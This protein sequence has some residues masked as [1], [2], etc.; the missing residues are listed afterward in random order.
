ME[1]QVKTRAHPKDMEIMI[2]FSAFCEPPKKNLQQ[3][4]ASR[5]QSH[6]CLAARVMLSQPVIPEE[7]MVRCLG[8]NGKMS[9]KVQPQEDPQ[10]HW[11][12]FVALLSFW[13]LL[14]CKPPQS[15]D[16]LAACIVLQQPASP[17][18]RKKLGFMPCKLQEKHISTALSPRLNRFCHRKGYSHS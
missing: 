6:D 3:L 12:I 1:T 15:D 17:N 10:R 9:Q 11:Y 8:W 14:R 18:N 4:H 16:C 7:G 5:H 13:N 2:L